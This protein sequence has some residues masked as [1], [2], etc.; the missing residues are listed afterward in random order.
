MSAAR[1]AVSAS[2]ET[3]FCETST[4]P[5]LVA[6]ISSRPRWRTQISPIRIVLRNGLEI[7]GVHHGEIGGL[8]GQHWNLT[9]RIVAGIQHHHTPAEGF[10]IV[11]DVTHVADCVVHYVE[12]GFENEPAMMEVDPDSLGR[13]GMTPE[14]LMQLTD[15]V[16]ERAEEVLR[17]YEG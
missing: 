3:L 7:L 14:S 12:G 9:E 5:P 2:T 10:D 11:C 6:Y 1:S 8:V 13:L 4:N 17:Q 16:R 15:K